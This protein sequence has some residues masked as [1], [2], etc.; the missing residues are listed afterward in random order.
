MLQPLRLNGHPLLDSG[1]HIPRFDDAWVERRHVQFEN[2]DIGF[3]EGQFGSRA[4]VVAI[5][6]GFL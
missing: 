3:R 4:F 2:V 6:E 5:G 1:V